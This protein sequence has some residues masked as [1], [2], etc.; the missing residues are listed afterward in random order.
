MCGET[1]CSIGEFDVLADTCF[2]LHFFT[3][4][5]FFPDKFGSQM[6]RGCNILYLSSHFNLQ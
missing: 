2:D 4:T 5:I 1:C 3:G 6:R